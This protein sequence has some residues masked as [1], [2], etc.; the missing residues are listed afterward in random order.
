MLTKDDLAK[1]K[2]LVRNVLDEKIYSDIK[3]IIRAELQPIK[4]DLGYLKDK[5]DQIWKAESEDVEM[6]MSEIDR[7]QKQL[8]LVKSRVLKLEKSR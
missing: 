7:L 4:Q 8:D 2:S 3:P 5:V 6:V 1:I